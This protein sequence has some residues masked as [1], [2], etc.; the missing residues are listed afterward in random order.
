M[1]ISGGSRSNWRFFAKHLTNAQDN[2]RVELIELRG[3]AGDNVREA[4][5]EMDAL[6]SGTHCRNFFYHA[7]IN[8][9]EGERL[10]PE[11]W[12]QAVDTLEKNLGLEGHSRFVVEH[13]KHGRTHRHV[14]WS[15]IDVDTMTA[16]SDSYDF[17][18]HQ[19]TARMLEHEFG[20]EPVP[21]VYDQ[22]EG[23]QPKRRPKS[24]ETF[25]GKKSG[26]DP[27][28][29][30]AEVSAVWR[31][32][33]SGRAF[34]AAIEERGYLL[35]QGDRRDFCLIDQAGQDH[36]L[37]R[38]I[39]GV[40]AA[41]VRARLGDLDRS[42]LPTVADGRAKRRAATVPA[43]E[44]QMVPPATTQPRQTRNRGDRDRVKAWSSATA[45][46]VAS[47]NRES[48]TWRQRWRQGA[49]RARQI[50]L[51]RVRAGWEAAAEKLRARKQTRQQHQEREEQKKR[52][53]AP[54]MER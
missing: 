35:C 36:S 28:Q 37:A 53:R 20:Q 21:G 29:V 43:S 54:E 32:C 50:V 14:I 15:R 49:V 34:K 24:W 23:K 25:R 10:A 5:R 38:R 44:P 17:R 31:E 27:A 9:R 46:E 6:A 42:A 7:D 51:S 2:E 4:L 22:V 19:L 26:I 45:Q 40:K 52:Q 1:I 18:K 41:E 33:D 12:E 30:K 39:E 11:Q 8:P 47:Q 3:V 13:E 48:E 16:V